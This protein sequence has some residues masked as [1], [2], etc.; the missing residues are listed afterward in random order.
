MVERRRM[1]T[2]K[3]VLLIVAAIVLVMAIALFIFMNS[4][5]KKGDS[6]PRGEVD[7][8]QVEDGTYLGNADNGLVAVDVSVTVSDH[9]LTEIKIIS[10]REGMGEAA[11]DITADM[12]A[13]NSTDVDVISGATMSSEMIK[14]AV[15]D[16]L[17]S[18]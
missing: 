2:W 17:V 13:E 14:A 16:A 10:H 8:A 7:L 12:I 11:E 9:K 5:I 3:K 15:Y 18:P 4:V 6:L 1:K